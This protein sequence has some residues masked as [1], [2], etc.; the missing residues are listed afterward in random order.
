MTNFQII[1][2]DAINS[3]LYTAEQIDDM[4]ASGVSLPLH[5]FQEWK[6]RGYSVRKGEKAAMTSVIWRAKKNKKV[7][8]MADDL[9]IP[10]D[11]VDFYMHKAFF[12]TDKQVEKLANAV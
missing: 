5:T 8:V 10:S 7:E 1:I 6:N 11:T 9:D 4:L 12:F 3:N 2:R